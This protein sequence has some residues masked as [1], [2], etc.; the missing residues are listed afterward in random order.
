MHFTVNASQA[1]G[2]LAPLWASMGFTPATLLMT[3]DMRQQL[4]YLG[5]IPRGG[6]RYARIHFLLELIDADF[7]DRA[8]PL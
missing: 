2:R 5:S 4:T 6:M 8:G 7:C 3:D 1:V